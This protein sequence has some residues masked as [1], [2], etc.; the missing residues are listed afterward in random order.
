MSTLT[1]DIERARLIAARHL[2]PEHFDEFQRLAKSVVHGPAFQIIFIDC[3]DSAYRNR[4]IDSLDE[5]LRLAGLRSARL[6]LGGGVRDAAA[7]ELRLRLHSSKTQVVHILGGAQWFDATRWDELNQRRERLARDAR[8]RLVL[9]LDA[10]AIAVLA[11]QAQ[12]LW[13]WRSGVYAFEHSAAATAL[14]VVPLAAPFTS[15][16]FDTRSMAQRHRRVIELKAVLGRVPPL[17]EELQVPCSPEVSSTRRC[18]FCARKCC[19]SSSGWVT[20]ARDSSAGPSL[21]VGLLARGA[22]GDREEARRLFTAAMADAQRMGLSEVAVIADWLK[23]V[24]AEIG[25]ASCRERV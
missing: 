8:A 14:P 1:F 23:S 18:A 25:R 9:W 19:Q 21:A 22:T 10:D 17:D 11:T 4:L 24:D 12:D 3:A 6:P 13:A 20:R 16:D 7:L 2:L 15:G 5:V